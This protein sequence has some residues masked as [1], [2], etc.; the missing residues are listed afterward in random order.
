[1]HWDGEQTRDFTYVDDVARANLLAAA[2]DGPVDGQVI[3]IG[4]GR[5]KSVNE[6]L[7]TVSEVMGRW[8][9]PV[10]MPK[11]QGDVRHTLADITRARELLGWEP[12]ADWTKAVAA[13]VAWFTE[14]KRVPHD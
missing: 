13:T 6:V 3:N 1:V 12:Q 7:A 8:I 11:R 2:A 9:E 5:A 14:G 4:A 10:R